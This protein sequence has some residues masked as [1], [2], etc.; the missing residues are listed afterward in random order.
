MGSKLVFK[1]ET[2]HTVVYEV[3]SKEAA[4]PVE[5]VY[6]S[7]LWLAPARTAAGWPQVIYLHIGLIGQ[8]A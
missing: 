4:V 3:E 8:E 1:K 2:K 6:V 5:S 7:K